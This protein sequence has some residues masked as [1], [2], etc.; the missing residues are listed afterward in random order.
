[1]ISL[2]EILPHLL[3]QF[4]HESDLVRA[5]GELSEAFTTDRQN[6]SRYLSDPR[7]VSAYTAF[8]L[9]TNLPKLEGVLNWLTPE[10]RQ[11]VLQWQLIDVGAGPGTFSLAWKLLGGYGEPVLWESSKLMREQAARLLSALTGTTARFDK[12][13]DGSRKQLLLFGH[14]A[15]E[16]GEAEA[17]SYIERAQPHMVMF[18]EPG[19]PA[20]FAL[21]LKLRQRFVK[22]GW[23]ILY[24]CLHTAT[25]P[26]SGSDW[27][28]QF[29][30]ARH[31][32]DVERLTQLA[33]KDRRNLPVIVHMYLQVPPEQRAEDLARIVRVYPPTKFSHEWEVCRVSGDELVHERFQ[34]MFKHVPSDH[35]KRVAELRSGDLCSWELEKMV[36][37]TRRVKL[38][39]G[40]N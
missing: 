32:P 37:N 21:M 18:I 5:V 24:P 20:V 13:A 40:N 3:H 28:H 12:L 26:L 36:E 17:W 6:I 30:D 11:E 23:H 14:S 33:H 7:L 19:T 8:Y 31:A 34:L 27:C 38:R 2:S 22:E 4:D 29:L 9:S 16:M 35:K 25:C 15:N 10:F 39:T 1:V